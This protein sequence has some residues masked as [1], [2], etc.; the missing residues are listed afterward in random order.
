M[1]KVREFVEDSNFN[2]VIPG[3]GKTG[4]ITIGASFNYLMESLNSLGIKP[5][6]LKIGISHPLAKNKVLSF[7]KDL[8]KV[9][10]VEE[11]EPVIENDVKIIIYENQLNLKLY[12]KNIFP[13]TGEFSTDL[14]TEI[15][16]RFF[17]NR[18]I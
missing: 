5:P 7:I 6:I 9:I 3:E 18:R 10:I 16:S 17:S 12:G 8:E 1:E 4:I 13:R 11:L 2:Y 14:V 15:L